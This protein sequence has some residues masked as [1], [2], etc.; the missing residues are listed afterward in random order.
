MMSVNPDSP[1]E[2]QE[3]GKANKV[4]QWVQQL[5]A[6]IGWLILLAAVVLALRPTTLPT[7]P[8]IKD[9]ATLSTPVIAD[10]PNPHIGPL[11]APVTIVEF[12]DFACPA[13]GVWNESGILEKVMDK[14]GDQVRFVWADFPPVSLD[15]SKAAEAARCAYDQGKFWEY[16]D[17][18]YSHMEVLGINDLKVYANLLGLNQT[19]FDQCLD[20]GARKTEVS[21]DFRDAVSRHVGVLPT[22]YIQSAL[23]ETRLVGPPSY[24]L[25]VSV[26]DPILARKP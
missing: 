23:S 26:I 18:L 14:Y 25:L 11:D 9:D 16:H 6:A 22:F 24:E 20:S 19:Q 17:Y 7:P 15:S 12:G 13:C 3:D 8:D 5:S 21:N 10:R 4:S 1:A 2:L